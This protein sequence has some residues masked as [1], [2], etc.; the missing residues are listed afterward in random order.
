MTLRVA[1]APNP[2]VVLAISLLLGS[3]GQA[4]AQVGPNTLPPTGRPSDEPKKDGVAEQ[5]KEAP[6]ALPTTPVLPPVRSERKRFQL[7]EFDG[8]FR[9]RT[10]WFKNFNLGFDDLGPGSSPYPRPLSCSDEVEGGA[11][12]DTLKSANMRLRL[13]PTI[14]ISETAKVHAQIDML[15]NVVLGST[16]VSANNASIP[17]GF[18]DNQA[19]PEAG[20]NDLTDSIRVKRA[21]AEARVSLA[22]VTFGRQPWHWGLGIF[23]N[24]GGRDPFS[25][26]LNNDSDFGD[27]VDRLMARARVPGTSID[28]SI[29]MDWAATSPTLGQS[30]LYADETG[31]YS[32]RLDGPGFDLEDSD[33]VYQWTVSLVRYDTP[34]LFREK[35]ARGELA[36]NYGGFV[37]YR[38]QDWDTPISP[39][40]SGSLTDQLIRRDL[41]TYTP[42]VWFKLGKDKLQIEG[43]A[44]LT[45]GS[46]G[47][48]S[49]IEPGRTD[50]V[51]IRRFGAVLRARYTALEGSM[52]LGI[53]G[54]YASGDKAQNSPAGA[55]HVNNNRLLALENGNTLTTFMFDPAY[56]IDL[57]L[58]RELFGT[59][60]NA[61][62]VRPSVTYEISGNI[63]AELSSVISGAV[64]TDATTGG[65]RMYG[66]E[67]DADVGY[68]DGGLFAG[69][70]GGA[71]FPF[72]GLGHPPGGTFGA[73]DPDVDD[74][75]DNSGDPA[76]AYTI[77][78]RLALEF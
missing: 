54:G 27:T 43:E 7:V 71:L 29:A 52:F 16:P 57:I 61:M 46:V 53:E 32:D 3:A 39:D 47:D 70:S 10:D 62:Y 37:V 33:D 1:I 35:V 25:G 45:L 49:D 9:F 38:T 21:W 48:V 14:N 42:D 55:L 19:A 60:T 24:S 69:V 15:D 4:W 23:A 66:V 78:T 2:C 67:I 6:E 74:A 68:R 11:C 56:N 20:F 59:I 75:I 5:A 36:L 8:Y 64:E 41:A 76:N 65:S 77:Q 63:T 13:E 22:T 17:T 72:S 12:G 26:K 44:V 18:D 50:S 40:G 58:F 34:E 51:D 28:A 31:R 30:G 73:P